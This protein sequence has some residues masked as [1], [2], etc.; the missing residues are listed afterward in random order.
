MD[1]HI[2]LKAKTYVPKALS[3]LVMLWLNRQIY[4][5]LRKLGS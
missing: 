5:V 1:H 3:V 2:P 4:K